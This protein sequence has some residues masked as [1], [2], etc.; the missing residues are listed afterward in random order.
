MDEVNKK[1]SSMTTETIKKVRAV[2]KPGKK[3]VE[4]AEEVESFIHELGAVPAFPVNISITEIAAHYTPSAYDERELPERALTKVDFGL[5]YKGQISDNSISFDF[6]NEYTELIEASRAALRAAVERVKPGVEVAEVSKAIEDTIKERGLKPISNLTGHKIEGL[7]LH[8][9][10]SI[11][12][13]YSHVHYR[14]KEGDKFAIEPFVTTTKGEG[15]VVDLNEAEIYSYIGD[16]HLRLNES[17]L[18]LEHVKK[19]YGPLP[20]AERWISPLI[21]SR[22]MFKAAIKE[23]LSQHAFAAYPVL[24]EARGEPVAQTE[25]T[26]IVE[27]DGAHVLGE[28]IID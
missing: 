11:P 25:V 4:I 24:K 16:A 28:G 13:V 18:L 12:N 17:R 20:F 3:L 8:A 26:I 7:I 21:K 23:L 14:F 15:R 22:L 27:K 9:G 5:A 19:E 10:V 6:T 1:L 2:V